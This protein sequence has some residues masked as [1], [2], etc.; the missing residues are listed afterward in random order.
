MPPENDRMNRRYPPISQNAENDCEETLICDER[1]HTSTAEIVD[2][3]LGI[4][5]HRTTPVLP[6]GLGRIAPSLK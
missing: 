3:K 5:L 1:T 6:F 2:R 4:A